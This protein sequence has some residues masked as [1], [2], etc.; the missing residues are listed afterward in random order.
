MGIASCPGGD[1]EY[2]ES[3]QDSGCISK[4]KN[5]RKEAF[6]LRGLLS[7]T[8]GLLVG[9]FFLHYHRYSAT[10][11][12]PEFSRSPNYRVRVRNSFIFASRNDYYNGYPAAAR[13]A[14]ALSALNDGLVEY[15]LTGTSEVLVVDWASP[16]PLFRSE[17]LKKFRHLV[18]VRWLYVS[19]TI[20]RR[21]NVSSE[22]LSE[23]HALNAAARRSA[24][25]VILRLDQDT[26][27]TP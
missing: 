27:L 24:G 8:F 16:E 25:D 9:H 1:N 18:C 6:A 22:H 4:M 21:Q 17:E 5:K 11:Q 19:E 7:L 13:L 23:V 20:L 2:C 26:I 12:S 15:N 3:N 10:K 14:V